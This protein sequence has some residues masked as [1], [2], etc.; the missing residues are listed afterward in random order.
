M[1]ESEAF[2]V[3]LFKLYLFAISIFASYHI[4]KMNGIEEA[5]RIWDR[6]KDDECDK[7][8]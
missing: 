1:Q 8:D 6:F 5:K 4:G 2:I 3:F 7:E